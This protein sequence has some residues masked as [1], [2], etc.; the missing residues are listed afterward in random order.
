MELDTKEECLAN[1]DLLAKNP[2]IPNDQHFV[3]F[4]TDHTNIHN[5]LCKIIQIYYM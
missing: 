3:Q 2:L 1:S 5:N 4:D